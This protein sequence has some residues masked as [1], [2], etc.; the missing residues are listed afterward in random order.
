MNVIKFKH[1]WTK[2]VRLTLGDEVEVYWYL[3]KLNC[4]FVKVTKKGFNILDLDTN[5]MIFRQHLY[6]KG[7]AGKEY[8]TKGNFTV[9]V[10]VRNDVCITRKE[11]R[12]VG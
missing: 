4:R 1:M 11:E 2:K 6:G 10:R 5:R 9:T 7:M 3:P 12:K 8:P